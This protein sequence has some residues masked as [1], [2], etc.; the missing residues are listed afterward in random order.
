VS[1]LSTVVTGVGQIVALLYP[2]A[3]P[4]IGFIERV[5]PYAEKAIPLIQAAITE[6]PA[7]FAAAKQ[8]APQFFS[9]LESLAG[10][11]KWLSGNSA[12]TNDDELAVLAS[13][14]AGIDP[15][16]WTHEE[17]IRWWDRGANLG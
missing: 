4:I 17:T 3:A 16:G 1:T 8:S 15:P 7:A 5:E 13:H 11:L 14:I 12:V 6:G 2:P 9:H 10:T